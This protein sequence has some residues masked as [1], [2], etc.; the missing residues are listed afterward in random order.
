MILDIA[1]I[2]TILN[3]SF[4]SI[5]NEDDDA[6]AFNVNKLFPPKKHDWN[7]FDPNA[8]PWIGTQY[9]DSKQAKPWFIHPAGQAHRKPNVQP[10]GARAAGANRYNARYRHP[11]PQRNPYWAQ[12][13]YANQQQPLAQYPQVGGYQVQQPSAYPAQP[14]SAYQSQQ[15]NGYQAQQLGGYQAQQPVSYQNAQPNSYQSQTAADYQGTQSQQ[16]QTSVAQQYS[17]GLQADQPSIQNLHTTTTCPA[18]CAHRCTTACPKECCA[19]YFEKVAEKEAGPSSFV[20]DCP[21]ECK[22]KCGIHCPQKCCGL[23]LCPF[24]CRQSC[25]PSC[26]KRCCLILKEFLPPLALPP[27]KLSAAICQSHCAKKCTTDCPQACCTKSE[28]PVPDKTT[29]CPSICLKVSIL[30]DHT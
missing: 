12:Q 5:E 18:T 16:A 11:G 9:S 7:K 1:Q 8:H 17:P 22:T 10:Y 13:Q 25:L 26:P 3:S 29:K 2:N 19:K 30:L 24:V 15:Q 28:V 20:S 27:L 14:Q 4:C 23:N 6:D 21:G